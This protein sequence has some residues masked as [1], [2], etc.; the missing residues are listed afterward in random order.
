[1]L[2]QA[3]RQVKKRNP[4]AMLERHRQVIFMLNVTWVC[5]RYVHVCLGWVKVTYMNCKVQR[6]WFLS[7]G[8]KLNQSLYDNIF[9][10]TAIRRF[11]FSSSCTLIIVTYSLF[12]TKF[13]FVSWSSRISKDSAEN[14]HCDWFILL[15]QQ[16][17]SSRHSHLLFHGHLWRGVKFA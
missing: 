7:T 1:M 2:N 16:G 3:L 13:S 4:V 11:S 15:L 9:R 6:E 5:T 17:L 8:S 12:K 10:V 14:K